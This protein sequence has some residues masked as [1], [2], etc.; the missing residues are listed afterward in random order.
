MSDEKRTILSILDESREQ[1]YV[2]KEQYEQFFLSRH[3]YIPRWSK[4]PFTSWIGD[5]QP[6]KGGEWGLLKTCEYGDYSGG[7]V[8]A[9]NHRVIEKMCK[10]NKIEDSV[11]NFIVGDFGY[12]GILI[13]LEHEVDED[14]DKDENLIEIVD[15]IVSSLTDPIIDEEDYYGLEQ[16]LIEEFWI[17][18]QYEIEKIMDRQFDYP[19][20]SIHPEHIR[21][22]MERSFYSFYKTEVEY[23]FEPGPCAYVDLGKWDGIELRFKDY[24]NEL[25]IDN[26]NLLFLNKESKKPD[27]IKTLIEDAKATLTDP[28]D[29]TDLILAIVNNEQWI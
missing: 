28:A 26:Q 17:N 19:L 15:A 20:F 12:K 4:D 10:D 1:S 14:D 21:D 3:T 23:K 7:T 27:R 25:R 18:E 24:T 29:T 6:D 11:I 13:N 9:S 2:P 8:K 16:E 5:Y 22:V